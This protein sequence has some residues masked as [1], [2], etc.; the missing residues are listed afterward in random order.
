MKQYLDALQYCL[1]YGERRPNRTGIDTIST[2]GYQMRFDLRE[3]FPAV[4]TKKLQFDSVVKELLWFLRGETNIKTLGSKIWD[5]WA[6]ENGEVDYC[7]GQMWR[8]WPGQ[9]REVDQIADLISRMKN[10]PT[11]RRH[12]LCAW[13]PE[14]QDSAGLPWCHAF[15]QFNVTDEWVDCSLTQRSADLALGVPFNIAS[16]ALLT[17]MVA[18]QIGRKPRFF[19]HFLN[20]MHIYENHIEGIREQL[21]REP[22]YLPKLSIRVGREELWD[23]FPQDFILLDYNHHPHIKFEVA[24]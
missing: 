14:F 15:V 11:S 24:V 4:T 19:N 7:Y 8:Q 1:S 20:D 16:Y 3:G 10:D 12:I 2:F 5:S 22:K 6:D 23:Y 13:H 21:T 9:N 18:I 17:H